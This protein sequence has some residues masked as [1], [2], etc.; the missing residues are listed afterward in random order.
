M[1]CPE[2]FSTKFVIHSI[3]D[4]NGF[5]GLASKKV[6]ILPG[7][8]EIKRNSCLIEDLR[9]CKNWKESGLSFELF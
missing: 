7:K 9:S 6:F 5:L 3:F 8:H 2:L 1:K 4:N